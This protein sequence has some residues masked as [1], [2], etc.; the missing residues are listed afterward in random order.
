M[1]SFLFI[2]CGLAIVFFMTCLGASTVF[3]FLK[4]VPAKFQ[5]ILLG[6]AA[7]IMI[8]ASIWSLLI[9]SMERTEASGGIGWI[10]AAIG[11]FAGALFLLAWIN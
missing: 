5:Q 2:I 3:I 1:N 6:F 10:T 8:A 4:S 9:P 11:F 7:G